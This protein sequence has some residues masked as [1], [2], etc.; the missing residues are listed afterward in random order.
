MAAQL[1]PIFHPGSVAIIG[2]SNKEGSFGRTFVDGFIRMGFPVIYPIHPRES[3]VL[4]LKAYPS[5]LAIAQDVDIAIVLT[6]PASVPKV[7]E[8]CATKKVKCVIIFSAGFGEK[9]E[10]GKKIEQEMVAIARRGG[11]RIIGPNSL[12]IYSPSA[13]I[14]CFPLALTVGLPTES[15]PVGGFSQSGSFFD[16]L[17]WALC[18]KGIRF[19]KMV[20][21]GNES[22]LNA[23]EFLEYLGQDEET[24]I[25]VAYLEGIKDGRRFCQLARQISKKKPIIVWKA[26]ISEQ[27]A[28]AAR[29]HTGAMA[30]ANHI[31]DAMFK[32]TGIVRVNS[33]AEVIDCLYAF[34]YL[35]LPKGKRVAIISGPGGAAVST[36][37]NCIELG[38]QIGKLSDNTISRLTK[39]VP[40]FGGT[41]DNP[42]D[43]GVAA[44]QNQK[45]YGE[46]IKILNDDDNVDMI[47]AIS[48]HERPCSLSILEATKGSSK[49]LVLASPALPEMLPDEY[50][51]AT[52]NGIPIYTDARR[53]AFVLSKLAQYAEFRD[54]D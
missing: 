23:V 35:P 54:K 39:V 29:S 33:Y 18:P 37:D 19:S 8:E 53:A 42:V 30:G 34:Y 15:G 46:A 3:S 1:D 22:D 11:T 44:L 9:G 52:D 21:C 7:I 6:P 25:I 28:K 14:L 13:K 50:R 38:L 17:T 27:G 32:Q 49:P 24:K 36:T 20:S 43:L 41:A 40:P 31:W 12:G 51:F 5:V 47:I 45:S 4:G 2:A 26:G 10:Q 16:Y 48:L